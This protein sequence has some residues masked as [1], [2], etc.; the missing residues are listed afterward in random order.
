MQLVIYP[1]HWKKETVHTIFIMNLKNVV[2]HLMS[3]IRKT[4]L[5]QTVAL[6]IHCRRKSTQNGIFIHTETNGRLTLTLKNGSLNI[7]DCSVI[8]I[9]F[10]GLSICFDCI[11][12]KPI[13]GINSIEN[14]FRSNIYIFQYF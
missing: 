7:S 13:F 12:S 11:Y 14:Y 6:K 4:T 2:I 8:R 10:N 5:S 1:I 3:Q 9:K